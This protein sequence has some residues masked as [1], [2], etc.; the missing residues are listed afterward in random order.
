MRF[1]VSVVSHL[2][3]RIPVYG[4]LDGPEGG[5]ALTVL[6][7]ALRETLHVRACPGLY[8]HLPPEPVL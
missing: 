3:R 7:H 4:N 2:C 5:I 6:E 8:E 1:I